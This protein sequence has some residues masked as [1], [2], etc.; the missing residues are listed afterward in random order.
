MRYENRKYMIIPFADITDE[1]IE[2][3]NESSLNTLRHSNK[4]V[5]R[6]TLKFDGDTPE[7]FN[8]I[9]TYTHEE[10]LTILN[11]PDGD[12]VSNVE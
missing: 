3:A 6:V 11:N 12:W 7:V 10:I 9:T 8:G 5:D 4:G 2:N 1:M